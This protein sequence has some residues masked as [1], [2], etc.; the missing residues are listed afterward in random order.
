MEHSKGGWEVYGIELE[1]NQN[2]RCAYYISRPSPNEPASATLHSAQQTAPVRASSERIRAF[3]GPPNLSGINALDQ[4]NI[5]FNVGQI[6][7]RSEDD[8]LCS[9]EGILFR[10]LGQNT[11]RKYYVCPLEEREDPER[12]LHV[13]DEV[14]LQ[15]SGLYL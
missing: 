8:R 6:V 10:Y 12:I 2:W 3:P 4:W 1:L 9:I 11:C 5:K 7:R 13:I 14:L 15:N